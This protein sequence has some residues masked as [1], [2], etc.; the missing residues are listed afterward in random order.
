M[1]RERKRKRKKRKGR[2]ERKNFGSNTP[3]MDVP[4]GDPLSV[5][6]LEVLNEPSVL[7]EDGA[8]WP[9]GFR[10]PQV[11]DWFR[12]GGVHFLWFGLLLLSLICFSF[13]WFASPFFGLLLLCFSWCALVLVFALDLNKV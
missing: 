3:G 5:V 12:S 4:F 1:E 10:I 8:T 11:V 13:L 7:E 9:K 2:E 6:D